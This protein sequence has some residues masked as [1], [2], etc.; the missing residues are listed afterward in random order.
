MRT[1]RF[2]P[3]SRAPI[4][5]AL[6]TGPRGVRKIRLVFDT[7]AEMTQVHTAKMQ[8]VGYSLADAVSKATIVGAGGIEAT[9][10][11]IS[12]RKLFV[13]GSKAE[14]LN[15]GMFEMTRL[16]ASRIDGLLGW[17]VISAF[18]LEMDGPEGILKIF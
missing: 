12:L 6:I 7:G 4:V 16:N 17:D 3:K 5:T 9:G 14:S 8:E 10:H 18:H 13:L 15:V 11:I 2:D 1:F